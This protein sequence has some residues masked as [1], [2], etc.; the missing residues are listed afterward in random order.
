MS[1]LPQLQSGAIVQTPV[2]RSELGISKPVAYW[3]GEVQVLQRLVRPAAT[4]V[5]RYSGL[6]ESEVVR[7]LQFC[8]ARAV[9]GDYI[10][11]TD[12]ITGIAYSKCAIDFDSVEA[13]SSGMP[14][15]EF[16]MILR[17]GKE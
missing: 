9:D 11:F 15:Y 3:G 4:W 2:R 1:T 17:S 7:L 8:E 6:S 14:G 10:E 5:L 13:S 16:R 12:P